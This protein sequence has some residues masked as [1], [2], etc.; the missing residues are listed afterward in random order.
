LILLIACANTVNLLLAR[1]ARRQR[2]IAVRLAIGASRGQLIR[3]L[4][5]ESLVIAIAATAIGLLFAGW[6]GNLL[7][8]KALGTTG[9]APFTVDVDARVLVFTIGISAFT[10]LVFGLS[11]AFRVMDVQPG[12]VLTRSGARTAAAQPRLQKVL[13]AFQVALSVMLLTG[14]GLFVRSL[15]N[16]A[17]VNVGFAQEHVLSV[18]IRPQVAGYPATGLLGLYSNLIARVESVP[19]VSSASV[20]MC[21]LASDCRSITDIVIEGY[22]PAAGE[23]VQVLE[24]RVGPQYFSTTGMH[25]VQGRDFSDHDTEAA[26]K[27]AIVNRAMVR[28]FFGN[29]KAIGRRFGYRTR[30]IEIVGIV[31]DARTTNIQESPVPMAFYPIAQPTLYAGSLDVRAIGDPR[32]IVPDVRRA[33]TEVDADLPI[34]RVTILSEQVRRGLNQERLVAGLT[35]VFGM[36][37]L[38]LACFGLFGVLSYVV[39]QRTNEIGIRL[40]LGAESGAVRRMVLGDALRLVAGGLASGVP[41]AV[42]AAASLRTLLFDVAAFDSVS[43]FGA[44]AVL[45]GAALLASYIPALRASRVD[46]M[47]A[48]RCE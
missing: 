34:D 23:L 29:Q 26:P 5:T 40:A 14:A 24:N 10:V 11:P 43:L 38:G 25:L 36:L 31:D 41:L 13:V 8:R 20:A 17:G 2:E 12:A 6:A 22:Q 32:S 18:W 47:V 44:C 1:A 3:Q 42:A 9:S 28:R 21:G 37:A 35:S 48:L 19:G 7:I 16:Y 27:V 4:V 46:P 33:V 45:I 30:D 15:R 39:A